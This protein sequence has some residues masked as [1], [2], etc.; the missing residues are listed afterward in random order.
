M[1]ITADGNVFVAKEEELRILN[2]LNGTTLTLESTGQK[3]YQ[4]EF[5]GTP[6]LCSIEI[7][8]KSDGP[9]VIA[10]VSGADSTTQSIN[11]EG[12]FV[13]DCYFRSHTIVLNV[14]ITFTNGQTTVSDSFLLKTAAGC[15]I[16]GTLVLMADNTLKKI[17]DIVMGDTIY[18]IN[19]DTNEEYTATVEDI[20]IENECNDIYNIV[21]NDGSVIGC[22]SLHK[23][24]TQDS[25]K[26]IAPNT[27][28]V[29][30]L[31][32]N[33]EIMLRN[34]SFA[35]IASIEKNTEIQPVYHLYVPNAQAMFV[36]DNEHNTLKISDTYQTDFALFQNAY[37]A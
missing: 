5:T 31:E 32:V 13:Y 36:T 10:S 23:W 29:G 24:Q 9:D 20:Y 4:Y 14:I 1:L 21:F 22:T 16:A 7:A 19:I 15:L 35:V 26:A 33:D 2:S 18:T 8:G 28:G 34:G 17:E 25:W 37:D 6:T 27:D 30:T 12:L 3:S 11:I